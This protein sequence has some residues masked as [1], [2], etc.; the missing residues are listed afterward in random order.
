[1]LNITQCYYLCTFVSH[2]NT[3]LYICICVC[4]CNLSVTFIH[5]SIHY[6][7]SFLLWGEAPGSVRVYVFGLSSGLPDF[8]CENYWHPLSLHRVTHHRSKCLTFFNNRSLQFIPEAFD[9][10]NKQECAMGFWPFWCRV[11]LGRWC[12]HSAERCSSVCCSN[13]GSLSRQQ[14]ISWS[15]HA[16]SSVLHSLSMQPVSSLTSSSLPQSTYLCLYLYRFT[17]LHLIK[18]IFSCVNYFH[19]TISVYFFGV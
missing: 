16:R 2:L 17:C 9:L 14:Y 15:E 19:V 18:V 13:A 7:T 12:V 10:L 3:L 8:W 1:M 4:I 5:P 11:E 6:Y